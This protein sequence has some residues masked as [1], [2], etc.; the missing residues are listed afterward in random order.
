MSITNLKSRIPTS[1]IQASTP[2]KS[3]LSA[4]LLATMTFQ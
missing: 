1:H 4:S 3:P 2:F